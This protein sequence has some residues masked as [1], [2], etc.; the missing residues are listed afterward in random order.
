MSPVSEQ[1]FR[2]LQQRVGV[3]E[4][5]LS[6]LESAFGRTLYHQRRDLAAL[7]IEVGRLLDRDGIAR[8]TDEE[9]DEVIEGNG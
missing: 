9:I 5:R 4:T 7:R 2:V 1:A 6:E 8:A 3:L